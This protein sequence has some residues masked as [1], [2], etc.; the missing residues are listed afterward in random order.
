MP[1]ALPPGIRIV[2]GYFDPLLA[3]HAEWLADAR[4]TGKLAV[5]VKDPAMPILPSRARAELVAALRVVDY[6]VL[7]GPDAP[8]ANVLLEERDVAA[9]A[10][11]AAHVRQRQG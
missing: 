9:A 11:F 7:D 2:S 1:T 8:P 6:V 5:I 4:G 10:A 3:A